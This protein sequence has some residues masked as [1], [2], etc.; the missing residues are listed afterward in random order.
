[1]RS[2]GIEQDGDYCDDIRHRMSR[3]TP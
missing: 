1:M 2:I 3:I